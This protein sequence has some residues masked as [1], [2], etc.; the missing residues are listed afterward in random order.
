[1]TLFG[2]DQ[3]FFKK[4]IKG[5]LYRHRVENGAIFTGNV[6]FMLEWAKARTS[7]LT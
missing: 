5:Y 7:S 4:V 3:I 6:G 1:M 2:I